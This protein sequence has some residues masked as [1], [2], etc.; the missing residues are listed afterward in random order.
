[1]QGLEIIKH[2]P[3]HEDE[4]GDTFGYVPNGRDIREVLIVR[5]KKGSVAGNHYHTGSDPSRNPEIQYI[6]TGKIKFYA[7]NLETGKE[8]TLILD[9][10]TEIRIHPNIFHKLE[11][12][13]DTVFLEFHVVESDYK[14]VVKMEL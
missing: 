7:K 5:R 8:E 4:R 2:K 6:I 12:M 13:E 10:N 14:D 3:R 1:M 11:M 9:P